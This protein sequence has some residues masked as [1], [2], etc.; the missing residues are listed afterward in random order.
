ML[1]TS[2]Y[3][4]LIA[5]MFSGASDARAEPKAYRAVASAYTILFEI[6]KKLFLPRAAR[7]LAQW[8]S[9]TGFGNE[10]HGFRGT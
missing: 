3:K 6:R 10:G 4:F 9:S 1:S 7:G 2:T 8:A 5:V